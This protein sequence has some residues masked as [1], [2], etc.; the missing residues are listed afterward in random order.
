MEPLLVVMSRMFLPV[1]RGTPHCPLS[2]YGD[3]PQRCGGCRSS[4][5]SA[6]DSDNCVAPSVSHGHDV[7]RGVQTRRSSDD[8]RVLSP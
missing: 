1:L 3:S 8:S 7:L 4:P 5:S 6:N 2:P